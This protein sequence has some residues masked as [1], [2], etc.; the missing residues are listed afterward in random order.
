MGSMTAEFENDLLTITI[1]S[2]IEKI[3][4]RLCGGAASGNNCIVTLN[5]ELP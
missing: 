1:S 5:E 2:T 3:A 4:L